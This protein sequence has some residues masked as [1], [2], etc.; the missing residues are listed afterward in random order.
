MGLSLIKMGNEFGYRFERSNHLSQPYVVRGSLPFVP[1]F[2]WV[3]QFATWHML[4]DY[5]FAFANLN[6]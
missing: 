6:I 3:E 2:S 1:D 5:C 4:G